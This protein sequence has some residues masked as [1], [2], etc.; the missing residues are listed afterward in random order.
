MFPCNLKNIHVIWK[1]CSLP[2]NQFQIHSKKSYFPSDWI[3]RAIK[4]S[5]LDFQGIL[6][7]FLHKNTSNEALE[8][9]KKNHWELPNF[10]TKLPNRLWSPWEDDEV[11]T[12]KGRWVLSWQFF[13]VKCLVIVEFTAL[14]QKAFQ[15]LLHSVTLGC[16]IINWKVPRDLRNWPSSIRGTINLSHLFF[17]PLLRVFL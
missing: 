1:I 8:N 12:S 3:F 10:K 7:A 5:P 4:F 16:Q 17:P 14:N 6:S 11:Q 13:S 2:G 9:I 15:T